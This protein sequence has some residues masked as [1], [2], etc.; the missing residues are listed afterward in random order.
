[1]GKHWREELREL[2]ARDP[3]S[4]NKAERRRLRKLLGRETGHPWRIRGYFKQRE[5]D[6]SRTR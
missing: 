3:N 4:L 5:T 2:Q 6:A 1:M